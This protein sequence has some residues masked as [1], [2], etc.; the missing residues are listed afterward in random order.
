V[1][2]GVALALLLTVSP[3]E[4]NVVHTASAY[5]SLAPDGVL[6]NVRV[7]RVERTCCGSGYFWLLHRVTVQTLDG[8]TVELFTTS[9]D[10]QHDPLP[11]VGD[12]CDIPYT[13]RK[14][15]DP[16]LHALFETFTCFPGKGSR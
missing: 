11:S 8:K 1:T 10:A 9:H 12:H 7:L 13:L 5:K 14:T 2:P 15:D 6:K 16:A 4:I 3:F